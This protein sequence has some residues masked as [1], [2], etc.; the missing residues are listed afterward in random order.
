MNDRIRVLKLTSGEELIATVELIT[1]DIVRVS[2]V[3]QLIPVPVKVTNQQ[4]QEEERLQVT[5][6]KFGLGVKDG[7]ELR[8]NAN[9]VLFVTDEIPEQ[10]RNM[11]AEATGQIVTP[12][13][14]LV[15]PK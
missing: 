7:A 14:G 9:L 2:S 15:L 8:L 3:L 11:Y 13:K 4:G 12:P 1:D 10:L 5:V 6:Y